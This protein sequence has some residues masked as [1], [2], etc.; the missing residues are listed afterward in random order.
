MRY[1]AVTLS[2]YPHPCAVSLPAL[3]A[4]DTG[5]AGVTAWLP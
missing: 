5:T 2:G 3:G 1:S 4:G